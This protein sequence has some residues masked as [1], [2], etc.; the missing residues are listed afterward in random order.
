M[1]EPDM[2]AEISSDL[3]LTSRRTVS[4]LDHSQSNAVDAAT[5]IDDHQDYKRARPDQVMALVVRRPN[6]ATDPY[7]VRLAL[8]D[9]F[10]NVDIDKSLY[11]CALHKLEEPGQSTHELHTHHAGRVCCCPYCRAAPASARER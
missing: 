10:I 8:P 2:K 4:P 9:G 1:R 6:A 5:T 3:P 11:A 7:P